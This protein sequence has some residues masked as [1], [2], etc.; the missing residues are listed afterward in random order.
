MRSSSGRQNLTRL[1]VNLPRNF[2]T[3]HIKHQQSKCTTHPRESLEP[4]SCEWRDDS[5]N[6]ESSLSPRCTVGTI[7]QYIWADEPNMAY[8][9]VHELVMRITEK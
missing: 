5:K 7:H 6:E 3:H 2:R 4:P 8:K 9:T 1:E